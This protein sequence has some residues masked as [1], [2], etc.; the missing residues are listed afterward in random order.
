MSGG[1]SRRVSIEKPVMTRN[2]E[3]AAANRSMFLDSGLFAI[4]VIGSPGAGKT[5]LLEALANRFARDLAVIEGDVR[6]RRDAD[7]V[8]K[9]GSPAWQ[10]ETGGACHLDAAMVRRAWMDFRETARGSRYLVIE[11]VGNLICPSSYDLGEDV[12]AALVS[13]PEGDDKVLKYPALFSRIDVLLIGKMDLLNHLDADPDRL[14][15]ECRSLRPGVTVFRISS[16]T[17]LGLP[18]F[19][20]FIIRGREA[21]FRA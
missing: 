3:V 15:S 19:C 21:K 4:N 5:S 20:D 10:I 1:P 16:K 14:E 2:D 12:K 7:R 6:T 9:A 13:L 18:E 11:N 8:E 17:G